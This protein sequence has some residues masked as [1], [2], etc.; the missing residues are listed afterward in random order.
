MPD[1]AAQLGARRRGEI[2]A[3][4]AGSGIEQRVFDEQDVRLGAAAAGQPR[5][6]NQRR[7]RRVR[8]IDRREDGSGRNHAASMSRESRL[9]HL[10]RRVSS[11]P[12]VAVVVRGSFAAE[13]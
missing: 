8:E 9:R 1:Q 13:E 6:E 11:G 5:G 4:A 7:V 12:F 10:S 3:T 2:D